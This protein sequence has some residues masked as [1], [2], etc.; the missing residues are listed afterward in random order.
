MLT[1]D[2]LRVVKCFWAMT[3]RGTASGIKTQKVDKDIF[4]YPVHTTLIFCEVRE[5]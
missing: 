2:H 1:E 5:V 4:I 3:P